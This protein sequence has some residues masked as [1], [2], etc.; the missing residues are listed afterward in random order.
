M[1]NMFESCHSLVRL[2]LSS[3]N[4]QKVTDISEMFYDD[5]SLKYLNLSNFHTQNNIDLN[6][7]FYNCK[8]LHKKNVIINDSKIKNE[9]SH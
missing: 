3:F 6:N 2:D 5:E 1:N 4:I 8:K 7:I 9:L